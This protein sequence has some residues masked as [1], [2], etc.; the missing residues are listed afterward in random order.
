M[1][2]QCQ[3]GRVAGWQVSRMNVEASFNVAHAVLELQHAEWHDAVC[4]LVYRDALVGLTPMLIFYRM[5][6]I[7]WRINAFFH[8]YF[9]YLSAL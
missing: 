8:G 7:K 9:I 1:P 6:Q 5:R 3:H 2:I 4:M